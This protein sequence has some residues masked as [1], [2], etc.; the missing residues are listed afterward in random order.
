MARDLAMLLGLLTS[1]PAEISAETI[2]VSPLLVAKIYGRK[3][4]PW[5]EE[6]V[7]CCAAD[8]FNCGIVGHIWPAYL[9]VIYLFIR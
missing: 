3:E 9:V 8:Q 5:L 6:S 1:H 2:S 4:P 7:H